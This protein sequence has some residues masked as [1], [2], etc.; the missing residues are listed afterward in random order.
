[1]ERRR[2]RKGGAGTRRAERAARARRAALVPGANLSSGADLP[3]GAD[4]PP[5][6]ELQARVEEGRA[7]GRTLLIAC[8]ALAKEV[9]LLKRQL[10]L[11][12]LDLHC[13]PAGWHNTPQYIPD[14]VRARI[15]QALAEGY[16]QV[17][18][19]YGDCGTGG[20]LDAVLEEER[21]AAR[22]A[23]REMHIERL[24]GPHCYAFFSGVE[25]FMQR[26]E[27][28]ARAYFL[29]DYLVRHFDSL[30][31]RG[32]MLDEHPELLA[33]YFGGYEKLVHLA[34]SDD[35]ALKKK[36]EEAAARLGLAFEHRIVGFGDLEEALRRLGDADAAS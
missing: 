9:M 25:A 23:G 33:D 8:G 16:R 29:T 28:D 14:G 22:E 34:Q 1:M 32:M 20:L 5:D 18:V 2:R 13:L 36:A 19:G 15:R 17:L 27:E 10:G 21:T 26:L 35:P 4:L 30:V 24:P 11:E 6:E 12:K 31:W 7:A 3:R